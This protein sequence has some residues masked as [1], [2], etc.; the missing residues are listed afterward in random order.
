MVQRSRTSLTWLAHHDTSRRAE[1]L[2]WRQDSAER[3][4]ACDRFGA[5]AACVHLDRREEISCRSSYT[6][7]ST[8]KISSQGLCVGSSGR[9]PIHSPRARAPS[10]ET[11]VHES[12]KSLKKVRAVAA[13]LTQAGAK[14][15]RKD[16]KR[17]KSAARA[18]SRAPRQRRDYRHVRSR[19]SPLSEAV[20][21]AHLRN[22]APWIG[23]RPKSAQVRAQ[24]DGVVARGR[25]APGED[26]QVSQAV[27]VSFNRNVRHRRGRR[28]LVSPES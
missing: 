19:S 13:F 23:P 2:R 9:P 25:R 1:G 6:G 24:R 18:L 26:A 21:R 16:R 22:S 15:P 12:R 3:T 4:Q 7:G 28:R 11:A 17:L 8:S 20:A 5:L 27:G 14:L 10:S